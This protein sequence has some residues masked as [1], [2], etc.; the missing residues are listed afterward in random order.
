V[1]Y[2]TDQKKPGWRYGLGEVGTNPGFGHLLLGAKFDGVGCASCQR[3][4]AQGDRRRVSVRPTPP[5]RRSAFL[6]DCRHDGEEG[7]SV[8]L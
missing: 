1:D 6:V 2:R 8:A 7:V 4:Y 3:G 5:I